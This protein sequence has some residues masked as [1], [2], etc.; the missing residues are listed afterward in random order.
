MIFNPPGKGCQPVKKEGSCQI[1]IIARKR[2][3]I[4]H[5]AIRD[6]QHEIEAGQANCETYQ[7]ETIHS[8]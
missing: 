6:E 1:N 3:I 5:G 2:E 8:F 4:I 7:N